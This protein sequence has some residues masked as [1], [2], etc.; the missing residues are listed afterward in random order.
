MGKISFGAGR[1]GYV[2]MSGGS[3]R[4]A[5]GGERIKRLRDWKDKVP[6]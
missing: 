1:K 2:S 5:L 4:M 3:R 6:P